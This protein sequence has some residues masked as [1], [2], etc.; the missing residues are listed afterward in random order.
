MPDRLRNGFGKQLQNHEDTSNILIFI[1]KYNC[2]HGSGNT[3]FRNYEFPSGITITEKPA[4]R[5]QGVYFDIANL[6]KF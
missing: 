4:D 6:F 5:D 3:P 2:L 1:S